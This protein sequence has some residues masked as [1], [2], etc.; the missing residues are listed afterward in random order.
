[1]EQRTFEN[2]NNHL[3]TNIYSYLETSVACTI[4]IYDHRFYD[5]NDIGLY[6]NTLE[7]IIID[8]PSLIASSITIV[9]DAPNHSVTYDRH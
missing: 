1:M 7:T 5:R 6:Y 2:V 3:N 4:N 9:S 8:D